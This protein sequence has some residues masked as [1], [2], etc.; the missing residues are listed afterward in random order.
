MSAGLHSRGLGDSL[1]TVMRLR[2]G[3]AAIAAI[4]FL[5]AQ[6]APGLHAALEAGHDFHSCCTDNEAATH[7][8][9]CAADHDAPPCQVCAAARAPVA[10]AIDSGSLAF[11]RA[12]LPLLGVVDG[13]PVD[14]FHVDTPDSRGPPA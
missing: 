2:F 5:G 12:E 14:P 9:A 6:V 8:D 4:L 3:R 13:S 1:Q 11:E 7:F 10:A